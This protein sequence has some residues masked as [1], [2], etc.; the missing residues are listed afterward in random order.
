MKKAIS[1]FLAFIIVSA[2]IAGI[3]YLSGY[4]F[5]SPFLSNPSNAVSIGLAGGLG[6]LLGP[7]LAAYI[8]KL[9]SRN[10]I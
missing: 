10:Q 1:F 7:I 4:I 5:K 6:G 9:F 2:F 3:V 8:S